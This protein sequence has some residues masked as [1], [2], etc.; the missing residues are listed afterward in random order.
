MISLS[1]PRYN[2][3]SPNRQEGGAVMFARRKT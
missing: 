1:L 3:L 2:S